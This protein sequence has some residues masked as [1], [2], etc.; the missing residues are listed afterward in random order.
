STTAGLSLQ[1]TNDDRLFGHGNHFTIGTSIDTSVTWFNASAELGTFGPD[2]VLNGSGIFLGPS[3]SPV[4]D[5]PVSLR[6]T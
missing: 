4:T 2:Y 5:G 3:G 1:A 6:A